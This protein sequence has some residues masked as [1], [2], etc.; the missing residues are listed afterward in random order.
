MDFFWHWEKQLFWAINGWGSPEWDSFWVGISYTPW[1]FP[2]YT[3]LLIWI[4]YR[5]TLVKR[6]QVLAMVGFLILL[7]DQTS[8]FFKQGVGRLR[9]CHEPELEGTLQLLKD[10]CGGSFG[11][12]SAHA[13]NNFGLFFFFYLLLGQYAPKSF[14]VNTARIGL[15]FWAALVSLSRVVIGVHYP[16]D[17]LFGMLVG[18]FYGWLVYQ[19]TLKWFTRSK[20]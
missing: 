1:S 10:H 19:L 11:F 9:P 12:F 15:L 18:L 14:W 4:G 17:V 5:F 2:I 6:A 7:S 20:A 13:S 8:Q 3:A 16:T